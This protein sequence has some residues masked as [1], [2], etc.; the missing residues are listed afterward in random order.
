MTITGKELALDKIGLDQVDRIIRNL[1]VEGI[2]EDIILHKEGKMGMNGAVMVDTGKY[3]GRSPKDK[4]FVDEDSSN[5]HLW[6]GPV[7][8][9]VDETIFDDLYGQVADYYNHADDSNTYVFD[10]FAGADSAYRLNV[11]IIAKKAWQAHFAHN[12]FIRPEKGDLDGFSPDFTIINASDVFNQKFE[13]YGMNSKTFII[14]HM[15]KRIA[16]IGGTEY[17]GEMKKGIFSVMNY[18][19]P[20]QGVLAMHCSAN[21]DKNGEN[22]AIFFGLSGTG[23]TTLSTDPE[24]PLIGDDEHGWSDDGIFN[25]EGGCYAKVIDLNREHEPDIYNAIRHGAL[26]ENVVYDERTRV[27]DFT[28]GSKTE[29]TRVSYPINYIDNSVNG[30]GKPSMCGH[31]NTIIF[32]TCDAYGVLPPVSKLTTEQAMYHFI[33]GYTAKVAGTER[34]ITEPVATFSPCFGGPFLTLHPLKYAE[35]L[36]QKMNKHQ[37]P[38]YLVNTGWV[39]ASAQSGAKRISLPVTRQII[40]ATL[41]GSINNA[42]FETD[43]YFGIMV[44]QSLG[45]IDPNILIPEKAWTDSEAYHGIAKALVQKFQKNFEQY[46]LGHSEIRDAGPTLKQ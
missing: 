27:I 40:H 24:R 36:K 34:G 18:M 3:T 45:D 12:M 17:G 28:D 29:N 1:P 19:L 16:I 13:E 43:P 2:I 14:F 4:Y 38:A 31:P 33:S 26:L 37:V 20:L 11:R 25:F 7:N 32:L 21:V 23:K 15:A 10:G 42:T 8:A 39:G 35:L 9:K 44:P 6:W 30:L 5:E 46:D 41:D 22:P